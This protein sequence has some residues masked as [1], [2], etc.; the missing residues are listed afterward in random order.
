MGIR[1]GTEEYSSCS[2]NVHDST[3]LGQDTSDAKFITTYPPHFMAFHYWKADRI[4]IL[5]SQLL[6]RCKYDKDNLARCVSHICGLF[7]RA[8]AYMIFR[9]SSS[10]KRPLSSPI[11]LSPRLHSLP[12]FL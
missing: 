1:G 2:C 6:M 9:M 3:D 11:S 8:L 7:I 12:G 10:V 5:R 4:L